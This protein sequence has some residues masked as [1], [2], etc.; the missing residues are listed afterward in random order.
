MLTKNPMKDPVTAAKV[1]VASRGVPRPKSKAG[2]AN[3]AAAARRRMLSDQNP[4]KDPETHR[5]A[6]AKIL[7][8]ELSKNEIHFRD[9]AMTHGL[10]LEH[11]SGTVWIGRATPDFRVTS[12]KKCVEVSQNAVFI[13]RLVRRTAR[14]YGIERIRQ[15]L[16]K[17]WRCLVVFK[18]CHRST[19]PAALIPILL[20]FAS[21]ESNWSGVWN[22]DRL[23]LFDESKDGLVSTT[24]RVHR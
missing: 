24:S 2:R 8:R 9:W 20:D 4:M 3:I 18:K 13:G 1:S 6:M 14:T 12:Q 19:I 11:V 10:P 17:G 22:Y 21:P 16:A 15:M 5:R 23:L 7:N